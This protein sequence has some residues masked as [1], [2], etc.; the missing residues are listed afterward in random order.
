MQKTLLS[1]E[2]VDLL[3]RYLPTLTDENPYLFP[4]NG[5]E[6]LDHT[7]FNQIVKELTEKADIKIAKHKRIRFHCFR[8]RFLSECANL[9]IDINLAK[10]MCGKSVPKSMLAYLSEADLKESFVRVSERLR[11]SEKKP[12]ATTTKETSELQ[13]EIKQLR[14]L[15]HGIA[16]LYGENI[17]KNA[18]EKLDIPTHE[19]FMRYSS[20]ERILETVADKE[21]QKQRKEYDGLIAENNNNNH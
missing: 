18:A 17:V 20:L 4:S 8:K 13:K 5:K 9:R 7:T 12:V 3:R 21:W 10:L 19:V 1:D 6:N 15:V 14:K 2:V 11:L 16:A